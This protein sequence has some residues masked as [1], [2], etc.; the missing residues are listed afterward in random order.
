M[1]ADLHTTSDDISVDLM[2]VLSTLQLAG[3]RLTSVS[4]NVKETMIIAKG[5]INPNG[6]FVLLMNGEPVYNVFSLVRWLD[7]NG[8][9]PL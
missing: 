3:I 1:R 8:M 2:A 9:V 6:G 5:K 4:T 7:Q